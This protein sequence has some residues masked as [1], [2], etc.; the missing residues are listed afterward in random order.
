MA[1]SRQCRQIIQTSY[2]YIESIAVSPGRRQNRMDSLGKCGWQSRA[3]D[4]ACKSSGVE[5]NCSQGCSPGSIAHCLLRHQTSDTQND[6]RLRKKGH[7]FISK[8][9][10][11]WA[12]SDSRI[13]LRCRSRRRRSNLSIELS[14]KQYRI[15]DRVQS[16]NKSKTG[17]QE[18][19]EDLQFSFFEFKSVQLSLNNSHTKIYM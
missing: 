1:F 11:R 3:S 8:R 5:E 19:L 17:Y 16:V 9:L 15:S 6:R 18:Y 2:R 14:Q 7:S 13:T 10:R 4:V 12:G